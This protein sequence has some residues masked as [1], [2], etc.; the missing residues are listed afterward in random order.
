M[1][2]VKGG[3][4]LLESIGVRKVVLEFVNGAAQKTPNNVA[5][6]NLS[7]IISEVYLSK[8]LE[9]QVGRII[10][11]N[12][13]LSESNDIHSKRMFWLTIALVVAAFVQVIMPFIH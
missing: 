13:R 11:S 9:I 12:T 1:A 5:A 2:Q 4:E 7:R 3:M 10:E 6:M 8:Q